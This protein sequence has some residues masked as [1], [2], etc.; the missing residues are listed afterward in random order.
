MKRKIPVGATIAHAYRF[1]FREFI[2][3]IR[4]MWLPYVLLIAA[5]L[6]LRR[7]MA[8]FNVATATHDF[9]LI[10]A[11]L[12][13][14][15]LFYL[16]TFLAIFMQMTGLTQLA[17]GQ[18]T[19]SR[20]FYFSLAKPLWRMIGGVL[21][22]MLSLLA[23]T[24]TYI[25]AVLLLGFLLRMALTAYA[26]AAATVVLTLLALVAMLVGYC[27][28]IYAFVRFVFVLVPVI[29]AE[30]RIGVSRAW[31]LTRG[32]FWRGFLILLSILV[33]FAVI[34]I[35][36][37]LAIA[38]PMPFMPAGNTPAQLEAYHAAQKAWQA[39]SAV[40][41]QHLWYVIYPVSAVLTALFYGLTCAAQ[42]FAYRKLT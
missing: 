11:E 12:G 32:N 25:L 35:G 22:A 28:F 6:L 3:I 5:A 33:P 13:W 21:L 41:I 26:P 16:V 31:T 40:H 4:I 30:S 15:I 27:A 42:A 14:V 8:A 36:G 24:I 17:L 18:P 2:P 19:G 34:E 29:V 20:Y 39:A 1:A 10:R 7:P 37:L 9:G 38:G 23:V